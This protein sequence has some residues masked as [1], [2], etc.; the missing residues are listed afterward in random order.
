VRRETAEVVG[1]LFDL[2]A[3]EAQ[4]EAE[5][6]ALELEEAARVDKHRRGREA[7]DA[8]HS[9]SAS[10]L[11]WLWPAGATPS[12]DG[13]SVPNAPKA[14]A[15]SD[16]ECTMT[17]P[18]LAALCEELG[19]GFRESE[20]RDALTDTAAVRTGRVKIAPAEWLVV[21]PPSV[22][23]QHRKQ[24]GEQSPEELAMLAE[25]VAR[26]AAEASGVA[27][28][29]GTDWERVR[30]AADE[31][32]KRELGAGQRVPAFREF[33]PGSKAEEREVRELRLRSRLVVRSHL[34]VPMRRSEFVDFLT[35]IAAGM[36]E[37]E[38]VRYCEVFFFMSG[39]RYDAGVQAPGEATA[40][41]SVA[42]RLR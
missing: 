1:Q 32:A 35:R 15:S 21:E 40:E 36:G 24:H 30:R 11:S 10:W 8:R 42:A 39:L 5:R 6:A 2:V 26:A 28:T 33:T 7:D 25:E 12:A 14:P 23:V 29:P 17:V 27:P 13:A 9:A 41:A 34:R 19:L 31:R 37:D 22:A 38:L 20:A 18:L 16:P 4:K 3:G